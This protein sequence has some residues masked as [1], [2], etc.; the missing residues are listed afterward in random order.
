[1]IVSLAGLSHSGWSFQNSNLPGIDLARSLRNFPGTVARTRIQTHPKRFQEVS[2]KMSSRK[3]TARKRASD[4]AILFDLDGTLLD[5]VYDH[6]A[7]WSAA[8]TSAGILV[9]K[10]KIHRRIGMSG[11]SLVPQ[12]L[13]ELKNPPK[14]IDIDSLEEK[15]DTEFQNINPHPDPLPGANELL[16]Y[17]TRRGIRWAIATTGGKKPTK[18]LLKNLE[19]PK[20]V[21]V[22]T[23]DDV[24]NAKPSP[25]VFV[26]AAERLKASIGDCIVT[27]DSIWDVLAAGRKRALPVGLLSGGYSQ[28]ELERAGAF[29]VYADP[30]DMLMHIEDLGALS[31]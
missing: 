26:L 15:H 12:L 18:R 28:E 29:R 14:K 13:R 11:K 3:M 1:M 25:D 8:L 4:P 22:V 23:G 19:I 5:T 31:W 27:G 2:G 20:N 24:A 7:A 21:L 9:P 16:E 17:L 10:W 6:V 30:A